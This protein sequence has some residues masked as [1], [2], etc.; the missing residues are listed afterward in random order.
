MPSHAAFS[1]QFLSQSLIRHAL[2][3]IDAPHLVHILELIETVGCYRFER[4]IVHERCVSIAVLVGNEISS[5]LTQDLR[6]LLGS[7]LAG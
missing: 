6:V 4:R 3:E 2:V 5:L 1:L 7:W